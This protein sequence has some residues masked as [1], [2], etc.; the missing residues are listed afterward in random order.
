MPGP[1][2]VRRGHYTTADLL[3]VLQ[4][5]LAV[6]LLVTSSM[7]LRLV[8]EIV[9]GV[10]VPANAT[11]IADAVTPDGDVPSAER[12]RRLGDEVRAVPGVVRAAVADRVPEAGP[13][14]AAV[15]P[16]G[17]PRDVGPCRVSVSAVT[18][19]YFE[20]FAIR[21]RAGSLFTGWEPAEA[22]RVAVVSER[23][24]RQCW[25][26][27]DVV[28]RELRLA[29]A[30]DAAWLVVGV[31]GDLMPD[32]RIQPRPSELYVPFGQFPADGAA[33][34]VEARSATGMA[35]R[36][37]AATEAPDLRP[38]HW[39]TLAE[40]KAGMAS[41]VQLVPRVLQA[42]A[43]IALVLATLGV[44]ASIQ[45]SLARDRRGL[46]IRLTLGAPPARLVAVGVSRQGVL[47]LVGILAGVIVTV[48]ATKQMF[49]ELLAMTAPDPRL[50]LAICVPLLACAVVAS[51]GPTIRIVR[52]DPIAILRR[53]DE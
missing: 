49:A 24:A 12:L 35:E 11:F 33:M 27:A 25:G 48:A 30:G 41:Q 1:A 44:Y 2:I 9:A 20:I 47:S 38:T 42:L 51:L 40:F 45:Q 4:V 8:G 23:T 46:A 17:A 3:V 32:S 14:G 52:L 22:P 34:L 31:V 37:S 21:L 15:E 29:R 19:E 26:R 28:G 53:A 7:F 50:W 6:V 39:Q 13:P 10:P 5:G 16:L 18:G 36:L 43:A